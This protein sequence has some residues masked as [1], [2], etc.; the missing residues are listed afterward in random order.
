[1]SPLGP[2]YRFWTIA[3]VAGR[4]G[5]FCANQ[6]PS[7][8]GRWPRTGS[9]PSRQIPLMFDAYLMLAAIRR[10]KGA[11][12][13]GIPLLEKARGLRPRSSEAHYAAAAVTDS[14]PATG[15]VRSDV[16]IVQ[17]PTTLS[18]FA[19]VLER[20]THFPMQSFAATIDWFD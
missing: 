13:A 19:C 11:W 14:K 20:V 12:R 9:C 17:L 8:I 10:T 1:M 15:Q 16:F 4:H 3:G 6:A 5:S 18:P 2:S 7:R